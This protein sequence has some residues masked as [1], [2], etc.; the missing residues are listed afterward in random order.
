MD[1][2][3]NTLRM[4]AGGRERWEG[5]GE[6]RKSEESDVRTERWGKG[7]SGEKR[8]EEGKKERGKK[9]KGSRKKGEEGRKRGKGSEYGDEEERI[10]R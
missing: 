6:K 7:E 9:G 10:K 5:E 4:E 2:K 3:T 8:G 1:Y